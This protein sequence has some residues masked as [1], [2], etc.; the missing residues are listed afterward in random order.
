[1]QKNQLVLATLN[2]LKSRMNDNKIILVQSDSG[3]CTPCEFIFN[4]PASL[5]EINDFLSNMQASL[6]KDY[7]TFLLIHNGAHLFSDEFGS[8]VQLYSLDEILAYHN[9]YMPEGWY[10]IANV[11]GDT[12]F[13]DSSSNQQGNEE[14]LYWHPSGEAYLDSRNLGLNFEIWLDRLVISQGS[15]Y[16]EWPAKTANKYYRNNQ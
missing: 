14:Y 16:W 9:S 3:Y 2:A 15:K 7:E 4:P 6:P 5:D 11:L 12:V 13:I 10:P 1:M 8:S